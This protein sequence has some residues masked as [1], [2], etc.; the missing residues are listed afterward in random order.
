MDSLRSVRSMGVDEHQETRDVDRAKRE[1][2]LLASTKEVDSYGSIILPSAFRDGMD[3][4]MRNPI[5]L[6]NHNRRGDVY[7]K[8]L[9]WQ[10]TDDHL[11]KRVKF[12]PTRDAEELFLLYAEGYARAWSVGGGVPYKH[13]VSLLSP[14][15][16]LSALPEFARS[17]LKDRKAF[18][19]FTKFILRETS[20]VTI[21]AN[22]GA[23]SRA[24]EDGLITME[25]ARSYY[26]EAL[27]QLS[28]PWLA[29][30]REH[31]EREVA[32]ASQLG[33]DLTPMQ[34]LAWGVLSR[35]QL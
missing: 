9:T 7:G 33:A 15:E 2:S 8:T 30:E 23:L 18:Y 16:Q 4:Y 24:A 6:K 1:L 10:I 17:A 14:E 31:W 34:Q 29:H 20:A 35:L 12:A 21:G 32:E 19:V 11:E 13:M 28:L 27:T 22:P 26:E 25:A 5:I 3:A